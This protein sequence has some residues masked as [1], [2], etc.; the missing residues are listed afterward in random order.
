MIA[1]P[2]VEPPFNEH[3][4]TAGELLAV[5]ATDYAA[6]SITTDEFVRISA[7]SRARFSE[8]L[9]HSATKEPVP[10]GEFFGA[11]FDEGPLGPWSRNHTRFC[12]VFL[13][14]HGS[15]LFTRLQ[16]VLCRNPLSISG[17]SPLHASHSRPPPT[18][19][20]L[21][22]KACGSVIRVASFVAPPAGQDKASDTETRA[23]RISVGDAVLAAGTY[24]LLGLQYDDALE[25]IALAPRPLKLWMQRLAWAPTDPPTRRPADPPAH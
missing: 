10:A 15:H 1:L 19:T 3:R 9:R 20:G 25:A 8:A 12:G 6:G 13:G 14:T 11:W 7:N 2:A 23:R 22:V 24:S 18:S 17:K 5:A 16:T 21:R 4:P